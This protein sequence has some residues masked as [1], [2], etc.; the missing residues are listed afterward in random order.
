VLATYI[1]TSDAV[2]GARPLGLL[3]PDRNSTVG[4]LGS[5]PSARDNHSRAFLL[6]AVTKLASNLF[7]ASLVLSVS[8]CSFPRQLVFTERLDQMKQG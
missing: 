1:P 3:W 2:H 6:D 7:L 4:N 5:T 8:F